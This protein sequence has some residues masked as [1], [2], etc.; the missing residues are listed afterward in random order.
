M[1]EKVIAT[2][3]V[4]IMKVA[5]KVAAALNEV[6][7]EENPEQSEPYVSQVSFG[8]V[9][10]ETNYTL[11]PDEFGGYELAVLAQEA[12][13]DWPATGS[14]DATSGTDE[15]WPDTQAGERS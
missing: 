1:P 6:P 8:W 10:E 3:P 2:V 11:Q 5:A 13:G 15:P 7:A 9:G 4:E 14:G 12:G